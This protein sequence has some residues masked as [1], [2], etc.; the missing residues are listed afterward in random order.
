[1]DHLSPEYNARA[2]V[3]AQKLFADIFSKL[4]RTADGEQ[5]LLPMR[6]LEGVC[7]AA[8]RIMHAA[9]NAPDT[10]VHQM[11]HGEETHG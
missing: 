1:M 8:V 2:A 10:A 11:A 5:L 7:V 9:F 3:A 4:P 6:D